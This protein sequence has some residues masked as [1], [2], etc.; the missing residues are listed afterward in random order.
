MCTAG[1][2]AGGVLR[3]NTA[4]CITPAP[5]S[6][7]PAGTAPATLAWFTRTTTGGTIFSRLCPPLVFNSNGQ[8]PGQRHGFQPSPPSPFPFPPPL[9]SVP[10]PGTRAIGAKL[11]LHTWRPAGTFSL[12]TLWDSSKKKK[13]SGTRAC[14]SDAGPHRRCQRSASCV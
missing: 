10:S 7:H 9:P 5:H 12:V 14:F 4:A 13:T 6:A 8:G 1:L 2:R 3:P 11:V